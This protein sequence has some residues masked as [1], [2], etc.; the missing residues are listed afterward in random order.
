M[1]VIRTF[2]GTFATKGAGFVL[3]FLVGVVV[4]RTL[5]P[6]GKGEVEA[7]VM[8]AAFLLLL[9]Y[10][11]LEEPQLYLIGK[12]VRPPGTI[13]ANGVLAAL[14]FGGLAI[15]V[16]EVIVRWAPSWLEYREKSGAIRT[17]DTGLLRVLAAV[18]PLVVAQRV[19]GGLLQGLRDMKAFNLVFLV[20]N[21]LLFALV[22]VLVAGADLG[23]LGAVCA[24]AASM[25]VGGIV[26]F[27]FCC[28]HPRVREGPRRVDLGVL[29]RLV[30]G[31]VRVHGGVA[32]AWVI[33]LSDQLVLN[34]YWGREAVGW[35]SLGV[36]LTGQLRRLVLQPVKEVLGSRLPTMVD[37]R[38][39]MLDAIGKTCRHTVLLTV[40]LGGGLVAFGYPF[41]RIVYGEEYLP[42]YGPLAILVPGSL[43]WA[44]AVVISYWF[45]GQ[46]RLLTLTVIGVGIAACNLGLNL[47]LVPDYG[48]PAAAWTS[49]FCYGLHLAVF[50][51]FVRAVDG[52]GPGRF[53]CPR[54]EDFRVY[55][56]TW[57]KL[58]SKL[59]GRN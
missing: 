20:Q 56:D 33:L 14:G 10:P 24:H 39:R 13:F 3:T 51:C 44:A 11:S 40:G 49:T 19:L 45:I 6:A 47:W 5:G 35:Y 2:I 34:R 38:E 28:R 1:G 36:A 37:D 15:L 53:L 18:T 46:D 26:A 9:A 17:M 8:S 7:L 25:A 43:L 21:V 29:G 57:R 16:F 31:G 58:V 32:A 48:M 59:R 4:S 41:L 30:V 42:S 27:F 12:D 52:A 23:V 54:R 55:L 22:I 50:L